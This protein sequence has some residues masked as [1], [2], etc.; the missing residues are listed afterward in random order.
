MECL[1]QSVLMG[2]GILGEILEEICEESRHFS[3]VHLPPGFYYGHVCLNN[4]TPFVSVADT[5]Q[6]PQNTAVLSTP[7]MVPPNTS[8]TKLGCITSTATVP[9]QSTN[10]T[11]STGIESTYLVKLPLNNPEDNLE[12]FLQILQ[13][14]PISTIKN[15]K[16]QL[17]Q[18]L[19]LQYRMR[20][21]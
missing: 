2:Q 11:L 9:Q 20:L 7:C 18:K 12:N 14:R 13:P 21:R 1:D 16:K 15:L 10:V 19:N 8:T 4:T 17:C 6:M 3:F 5:S